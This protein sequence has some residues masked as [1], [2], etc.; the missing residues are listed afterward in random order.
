MT[1]AARRV[2]ANDNGNEPRP[3][4]QMEKTIMKTNFRR[5]AGL[6]VIA[7]LLALFAALPASAANVVV[8]LSSFTYSPSIVSISTGDSVT[9]TNKSGFHSATCQNAEPLCGTQTA[10]ASPW[11]LTWVFN[12]PGVFK[13]RCTVHSM[14][15]TSGMIGSVTVLPRA[16]QP[17]TLTIT[18]PPPGT[19]FIAPADVT[20]GASASDSDG[21]VSQVEFFQDGVS[22]GVDVTEP[23]A[24]VAVGLSAGSYDFAAVAMDNTG[25]KATNAVTVTVNEPAGPI[26]LTEPA[27]A[28][29]DLHVTVNG[30]VPGA[31]YELQVSATLTDGFPAPAAATFTGAAGPVSLVVTNG[32]SGV[33]KFYRVHAK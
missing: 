18:N 28:G 30:T 7:I 11:A 20:L 21:T 15:F 26:T 23:Y 1:R 27:V 5:P 10:T 17:P 13:Y 9:F 24:A 31:P 8:T 22:L 33:A 12:S 14:S 3:G 6:W 32:V 16:N 4:P 29:A 19:V 2:I 25:A